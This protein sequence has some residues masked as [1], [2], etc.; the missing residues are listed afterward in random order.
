MNREFARLLEKA[1]DAYELLKVEWKPRA[2]RRAAR[3]IENYR[4]DISDIYNEEGKKGLLKIPGVGEG[5]AGH[6]EEYIKS[7]K[8]RKWE[9]LFSG[10][11]EVST[12]LMELKGLGPR[13]VAI[14][15]DRLKIRSMEDLKR[16]VREEKVRKIPGFGAATEKNIMESILQYRAGHE[17]MLISEALPAAERIVQYLSEKPGVGRVDYTGSLRRMSETIGDIDILASSDEPA[18]VMEAF[19]KMPEVKRVLAR[20]ATKSSVML[21]G[22]LQVDLRVVPSNVYGAALQYFTGNKDHNVEMRKIA[23]KRGLKLSE[24][25][26][27]KGKEVLAGRTE[28]EVY[29]KLGLAYIPP[30]MREDRGEIEAAKAGKMPGLIESGDIRG[31]LHMHTRYSDGLEGVGEMAREAEKLGYEYIAITD[32]S[33]SERIARGVEPERLK[34]Q[35]AEIDRVAKK[36]RV[37][38]LKGAEVDI[39]P[40]GSLDYPEEVLKRL[41]VAVC[42]IHSGFRMGMKKMTER[43]T[44][45][46]ENPHLDILAHPTGRMIGKREGYQIDLEAVFEAAAERKKILEIDSQAER[47]DLNDT[48]IMKAREYGLRFSISSDAHSSGGLY[49]MRYGLGQARRGWLGKEDVVN[50]LPLPELLK[51]LGKSTAFLS[52]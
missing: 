9:K 41:D 33:P 10:L 47:L 6:I 51:A 8:V 25:G 27:L 12:E 14:L 21:K 38:I 40:D 15:T 48:H 17:R 45:A 24:Y 43:V 22:G 2:Y 1:A 35:W 28:E 31:D 26:L 20:G 13:K 34:E 36:S 11:P 23:I 5:I 3:G 4:E 42:S 46:L 52:D 29:G 44:T 16:A 49:H 32:H 18:A 37:R 39:L 7:G 30:E 19:T 50:A